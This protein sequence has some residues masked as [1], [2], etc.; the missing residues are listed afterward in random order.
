MAHVPSSTEMEAGLFFVRWWKE[1]FLGCAA[2]LTMVA[3][4]RKGS[5]VPIVATLTEK[6]IAE[7]VVNKMTICKY[8]VKAEIATDLTAAFE[9]HEKRM[10][11]EIKLLIKLAQK[12]KSDG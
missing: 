7:M 2:M 10:L 9:A 6:Q 8:Q 3:M 1:F 5:K 12:E 11:N 4:V